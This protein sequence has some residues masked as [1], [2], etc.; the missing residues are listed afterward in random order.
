MWNDNHKYSVIQ[1]MSC[2]YKFKHNICE[3]SFKKN[4]KNSA[5]MQNS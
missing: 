3:N 4:Y 2:C 1:D 5:K